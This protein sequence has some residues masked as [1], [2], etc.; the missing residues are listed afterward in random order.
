VKYIVVGQLER[1][2][3]GSTDAL[4]PD[5]TQ[6]FEQYEGQYWREVYSD[7]STAIYEVLP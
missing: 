3:Y 7:G 2:A 5:G 4:I 6:K 1:A